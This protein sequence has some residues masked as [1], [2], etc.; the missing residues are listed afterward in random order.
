MQ[1]FLSSLTNDHKSTEMC[2]KKH[3]CFYSPRLIGYTHLE[4]FNLSKA[5]HLFHY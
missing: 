5:K 1:C 3:L 4:F 2:N